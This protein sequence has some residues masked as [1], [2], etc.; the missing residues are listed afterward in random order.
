MHLKCT[1]AQTKRY[2]V[3]THVYSDSL[4]IYGCL[5]DHSVIYIFNFFITLLLLLIMFFRAIVSHLFNSPEQ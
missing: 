5:V 3:H 1:Y 4:E 2:S